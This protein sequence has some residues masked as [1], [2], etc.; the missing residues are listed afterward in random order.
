MKFYDHVNGRDTQIV[1]FNQ[2]TSTHHVS[3]ISASDN[4]T[5]MN[6]EFTDR[7][8]IDAIKRGLLSCCTCGNRM[9]HTSWELP[10]P[11][12]AHFF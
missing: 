7:E 2:Q 12:A 9:K 10:N 3:C 5:Y 1:W 11:V 4:T 6:P 8:V